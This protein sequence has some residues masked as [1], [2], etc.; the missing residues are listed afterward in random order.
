MK[1]VEKI[2]CLDCKA[3]NKLV[4]LFIR[5]P[6][7]YNFVYTADHDTLPNDAYNLVVQCNKCSSIFLHPYYFSEAK[8]IY[9]ANDYYTDSGYYPQNIHSGGGPYQSANTYY[10]KNLIKRRAKKYLKYAGVTNK[11]NIRCI[12]IGCGTGD[13]IRALNDLGVNCCGTDINEIVI[14]GTQNK[15]PEIYKGYFEEMDF[16]DCTFDL[17]IS[18]GVLEHMIGIDELLIKISKTL[19]PGGKFLFQVPNDID[20]YRSRFFRKIW[21]IIPPIHTRYYTKESIKNIF[22][23]YGLHIESIKTEGTIGDDLSRFLLWF[24]FRK[25]FKV[26]QGSI[27]FKIICKAFQIIFKP[28]DYYLNRLVFHSELI[29]TVTKR[30]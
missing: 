29:V 12:D 21:W 16:S 10:I 11:K 26:I 7:D 2:A 3:V 4:T 23:N 30:I 24:F 13:L 19:K 8:D 14:E 15:K 27:I 28:V 1:K 5:V 22:S 20:G 6:K 17:I 25:H 18:R 9:N